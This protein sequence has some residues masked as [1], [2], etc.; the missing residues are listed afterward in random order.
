VPET[1]IPTGTGTVAPTTTGRMDGVHLV[2]G[3]GEQVGRA[4]GRDAILGAGHACTGS[5][6]EGMLG[7]VQD[8]SDCTAALWLRT[9]TVQMPPAVWARATR[10]AP[11]SSSAAAMV[12]D[13][14][15]RLALPCYFMASPSP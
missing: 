3:D 2:R 7:I 10:P 13:R 8:P 15:D 6:L 14:R 5:M 12:I 9:L 11:R 4:A 1:V